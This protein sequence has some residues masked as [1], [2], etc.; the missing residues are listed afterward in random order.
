LTCFAAD[1]T[2]LPAVFAPVTVVSFAVP[3]APLLFAGLD[4]LRRGDAFAPDLP[5][6]AL[7]FWERR[8]PERDFASARPVAA[9]LRALDRLPLELRPDLLFVC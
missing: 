5:R 7:P 2:A 6:D 3:M 8:V 1:A 4:V 9:D